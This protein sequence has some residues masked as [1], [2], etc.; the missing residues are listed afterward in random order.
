MKA[1][2]PQWKIMF[3]EMEGEMFL[4]LIII[5]TLLFGMEDRDKK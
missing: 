5:K 4:E 2:I 3:W 1:A